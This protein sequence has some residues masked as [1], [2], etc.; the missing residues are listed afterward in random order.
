MATRKQSEGYS[1]LE[2]QNQL[3][4]FRSQQ[5]A[6][7]I[8]VTETKAGARTVSELRSDSLTGARTRPPA[9]AV[10]QHRSFELRATCR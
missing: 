9:T 7:V 6:R 8:A 1:G 4:R 5:A 10:V 3:S 2:S